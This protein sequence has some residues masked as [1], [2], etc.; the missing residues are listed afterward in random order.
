VGIPRITDIGLRELWEAQF[1][2][3]LAAFNL[4][5]YAGRLQGELGGLAPEDIDGALQTAAHPIR[6][7]SPPEVVRGAR[8]V[9]AETDLFFCGLLLF[10]LLTGRYPFRER[11]DY[12]TLSKMLDPEYRPVSVQRLNPAVP[13]G[14]A[15]VVHRAIDKDPER[16]FAR[17][18]AFLCALEEVNLQAAE[19]SRGR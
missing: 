2:E 8:P 5:F 13:E 1:A 10:E 6:L 11:S 16:R 18:G 4:G 9:G 19:V 17:A 14:L 12:T 7:Y 3:R 15:A